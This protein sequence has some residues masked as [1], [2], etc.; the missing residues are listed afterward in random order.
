M[1]LPPTI[2][3]AELAHARALVAVRRD[4]QRMLRTLIGQRRSSEQGSRNDSEYLAERLRFSASPNRLAGLAEFLQRNDPK[5]HAWIIRAY[6]SFLREMIQPLKVFEGPAPKPRTVDFA[7]LFWKARPYLIGPYLGIQQNNRWAE[8]DLLASEPENKRIIMTQTGGPVDITLWRSRMADLNA[9]LSCG[10]WPWTWTITYHSASQ[11]VLTRQSQ[12]PDCIPYDRRYLTSGAL[13]VGIDTTQRTP[14]HIPFSGLTAGTYIPG[15]A[16][17]GKTSAMHILLRSIF[18]NL[19][20]FEAVWLVDGKD[21]VALS[22]YSHLHPKIRVLYDEADVWQLAQRLTE[23]MKERNAQQRAQGID[24]ATS[25]FIAVLIDEL[26]TF[27]ADPPKAQKKEHEAFLDNLN[28]IAMR[29]RSAG[30]RLFLISQTPVKEQIP[31]TL[32][33]N[34]STVIAFRLPEQAH[35]T[36]IFGELKALPEDPRKLPTG[37]A[38]VL[39][40]ESGTTNV[41]QFPFAELYKPPP[42]K[43]P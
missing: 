24:K 13:F 4:R 8:L 21:G 22:R 43:A 42:V 30:I 38:I 35:A 9:W 7:N 28:K 3:P 40:G 27:I 25:G 26:P 32:R 41:V 36:S 31:V 14:V 5:H 29:G 11:V 15:T 10:I 20:L 34:C 12:L 33:A 6:R 23:I 39:Q 18:A 19:D 37:Q 17:S 1:N 16:G 2:T